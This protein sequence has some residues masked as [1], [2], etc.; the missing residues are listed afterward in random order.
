[1][2]WRNWALISLL[3]SALL[4]LTLAALIS[5]SPL[6]HDL[7]NFRARNETNWTPRS[8]RRLREP[9]DD[10]WRPAGHRKHSKKGQDKED[11]RCIDTLEDNEDGVY[12]WGGEHGEPSRRRL[13]ESGEEREKRI[14]WERWCGRAYVESAAVRPSEAKDERGAWTT[15]DLVTTAN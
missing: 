5:T 10:R 13:E 3:H 8:A 6:G 2:F 12:I 9:P 7:G 4:F 15:S 1:M 11:R 14:D